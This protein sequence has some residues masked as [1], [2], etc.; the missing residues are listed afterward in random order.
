[1]DLFLFLSFSIESES[2][3]LLSL[4]SV[5]EWNEFN[6]SDGNAENLL[7]PSPVRVFSSLVNVSVL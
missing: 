6:G 5:A 2:D 7:S 3:S 1:M 4:E